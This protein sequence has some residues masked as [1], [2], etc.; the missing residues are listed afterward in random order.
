MLVQIRK[1]IEII[2]GIINSENYLEKYS[3]F[4]SKSNEK[5]EFLYHNFVQLINYHKFDYPKVIN[6]SENLQ[7]CC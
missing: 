3:A 6:H 4:L 1:E 2:F 7:I 5:L